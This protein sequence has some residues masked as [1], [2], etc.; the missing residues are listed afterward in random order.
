MVY[1]IGEPILEAPIFSYVL[2]ESHRSTV[3]ENCLL[4]PSVDTEKTLKR[5]SGCSILY[6]CGSV[7]Q[8]ESWRKFHRHECKY[9]KMLGTSNPPKTLIFLLR[10]LIKL[11]NGGESLE[12]S[13]PDNSLPPRRFRD[14]MT[15]RESVIEDPIR[16]R[17]F[18][19]FLFILET[20]IGLSSSSPLALD[21]AELLDIFCRILINSACLYSPETWSPVGVFLSLEFSALDHSCAPNVSLFFSQGAS[22]LLLMPRV[23]LASFSEA[24]ISYVDP[25]DP[26]AVRRK[27]LKEMFYFDCSCE[28]CVHEETVEDYKGWSPACPVCGERMV[29]K[30]RDCGGCGLKDVDLGQYMRLKKEFNDKGLLQGPS[31]LLIPYILSVFRFVHPLDS[32]SLDFVSLL[33]SNPMLDPEKTETLYERQL[34]AMRYIDDHSS[35]GGGLR[36]PAL[37][38]LI[39]L[40]NYVV[41]LVEN[42]DSGKPP[43]SKKRKGLV[44]TVRTARRHLG[45]LCPK[46]HPTLDSMGHVFD[47]FLRLYG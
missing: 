27:F 43:A 5:C 2:E 12:T 40:K 31:D 41:V 13:F 35:Q 30:A 24:R 37:E 25:M 42:D 23:P 28:A 45:L 26:L 39:L 21:R 19:M 18:L 1:K 22:S 33:L 14:L 36:L 47:T 11:R 38:T 6:Y 44:G 7:C 10:T 15:H 9:F 8:R 3:C 20:K 29:K 4:M 34:L 46:G 17:T 32:L 16:N